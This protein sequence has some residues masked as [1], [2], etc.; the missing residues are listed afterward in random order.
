MP[1]GSASRVG[2]LCHPRD[3]GSSNIC[4]GAET[5]VFRFQTPDFLVELFHARTFLGGSR[6]VNIAP[7]NFSRLPVELLLFQASLFMDFY[8]VK[9]A[10]EAAIPLAL[11]DD[12]SFSSIRQDR[13]PF[14]SFGLFHASTF[15]SGNRCSRFRVSGL[16]VHFTQGH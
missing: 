4:R 10:L 14:E 13:V 2:S 6:V 3:F 1:F 7:R 5:V 16:H 8:I 12:I 11:K 15:G 9:G